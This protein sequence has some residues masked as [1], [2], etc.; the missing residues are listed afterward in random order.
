MYNIRHMRIDILTLFPDMFEG[1][2]RE[3]ILRRAQDKLLVE[4][5]IHQLRDWAEGKHKTVDDR[6]FGGGTGMI[7]MIEPLEKA[8]T[9]LKTPTSHTILLDP[10]GKT[11]TQKSARELSKEDHLILI[12]A[13]YETV[14]HRVREHLIDEEISIGDYV[15]TGGELPA[16]VLVDAVVRL[17]PGVLTKEDATIHESFEGGL[18]EYPQYTRPENFRGWKI[19]EVLLS[20]NHKAI[21]VWKKSA[22]LERTKKNRADLLKGNTL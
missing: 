16:M 20:G 1:P 12:A 8:L 3:S 13:H 2:F 11:F 21:E 15:L 4:I 14:D 22:A 6:P 5:H 18:L 19:P 17:L 9:S 7:L 10:G